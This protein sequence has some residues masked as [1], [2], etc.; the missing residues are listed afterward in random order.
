MW[1]TVMPN[2]SCDWEPLELRLL[3]KELANLE[4][5]CS[6]CEPS[7]APIVL[8][9]DSHQADEEVQVET[10][11]GPLHR[12]ICGN[13]NLTIPDKSISRAPMIEYFRNDIFC[14]NCLFIW[15]LLRGIK[16]VLKDEECETKSTI[17]SD[18]ST[19]KDVK[20][21]DSATSVTNTSDKKNTSNLTF[22]DFISDTG[23]NVTDN[24]NVKMR[25][26]HDK[27]TF[28]D[29]FIHDSITC[30]KREPEIMPMHGN[31][32][33]LENFIDTIRPPLKIL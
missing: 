11:N 31:C 15:D 7:K 1:G 18:K 27:V 23:S 25:P 20:L 16:K 9:Q 6:S 5:N 22:C 30:S 13:S 24:T 33:C 12:F 8:T 28:L 2:T 26:N 29:D 19:E 21:V 14:P 17:T 3:K 32:V 10:Y 4:C